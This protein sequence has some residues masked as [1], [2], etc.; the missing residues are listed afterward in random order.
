MLN[1]Q[2]SAYPKSGLNVDGLFGIVVFFLRLSLQAM[3][4]MKSQT[5][6]SQDF[7]MGLLSSA[8]RRGGG[9][10]AILADGSVI[11]LRVD[12]SPSLSL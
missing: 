11:H 6:R 4:P 9:L 10:E 3:C 8:R 2:V 12:H 7:P 5:V 1:L